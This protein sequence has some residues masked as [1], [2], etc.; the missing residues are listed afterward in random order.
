MG[1]KSPTATEGRSTLDTIEIYW[2]HLKYLANLHYV[3]AFN[4]EL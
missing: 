1:S 2:C 4:L 3:P